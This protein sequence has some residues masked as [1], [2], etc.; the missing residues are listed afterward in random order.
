MKKALLIVAT[1]AAAMLASC[2]YD[3]SAVWDKIDELETKVSDLE[4][5]MDAMKNNVYV[6]SVTETTTAT[7]LNLPMA[8]SN[9]TTTDRWCQRRYR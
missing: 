8:G 7:R 1:F 4:T 6:K 3:D 9:I 2:S 5:L